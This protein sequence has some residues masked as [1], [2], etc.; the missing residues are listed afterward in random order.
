MPLSAI[1][2]TSHYLALERAAQRKNSQTDQGQDNFFSHRKIS[3]D[4]DKKGVSHVGKSQ[5]FENLGNVKHQILIQ[6]VTRIYFTLNTSRRN[7][8]AG[9]DS[10]VTKSKAV[11]VKR[12][13]PHRS[14]NSL[15]LMRST[16]R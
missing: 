9:S 11:M 13:M 15:P 6:G 1:P 16:H 10:I 8:L 5:G 3:R 14:R 7:I 12:T 2:S 4:A